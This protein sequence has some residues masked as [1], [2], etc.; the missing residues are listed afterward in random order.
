MSAA[1]LEGVRRP[2][3]HFARIFEIQ[4][5]LADR[6]LALGRVVGDAHRIIVDAIQMQ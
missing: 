4:P 3:E 2:R 5:A 6:A 1:V